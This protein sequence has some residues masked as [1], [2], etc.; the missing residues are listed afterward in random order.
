[1]ACERALKKEAQTALPARLRELARQHKYRYGKVRIKKLTSRWGSCSAKND[2]SLSYFLVQLPAEFIDYV[3]LH[4]LV[5]TK[6]LNHGPDFWSAFTNALPSARR[7]QKQ[8]KAYHPRVEP[9]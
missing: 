5:H 8:I 9:A 6:Y 7:L 3:I 4:E 1:M 2:I